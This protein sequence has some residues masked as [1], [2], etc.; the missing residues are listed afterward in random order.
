MNENGKLFI[1]DSSPPFFVRHPEDLINWSKIPYQQLEKDGDFHKKTHRKIRSD[2]EKY[3]HEIKKIGYNS[4]SLDDLSHMISFDFYPESLKKKIEKYKTGF[5][6]LFQKVKKY[7]LK[8][9]ITTDILFFNPWIEKET[10]NEHTKIIQFLFDAVEKLFKENEEIDGIIFRIGESDGI[11]VKGDFKSRLVLKT[12]EQVNYCLKK[13]LPLFEKYG[14][15]I[16]FRTWTTG[17]Y[18]IGDLMWNEKSFEKAFNGIESEFF[19]LSMKYG[20]TDF[21]R[22]LK[23]SPF[24][25][26][27][28]IK[29]IVEL[30][31]RREY[32]GFGE[33]PS[34]IGWD[35]KNYQNELKKN[36]SVIGI[37]AWCQTGGWSQFRNFTFLKNTSFWNE[38]NTFS[39]LKIFRYN[40]SAE[41]SIR[42]FYKEKDWKALLKFLRLS[43]EVIKDLLYDPEF[44]KKEL[45]FNRVRIPPLIH[46]I[47]DN[48]TITDA[49]IQFYNTY[50]VKKEESVRTAFRA[51]SKIKKMAKISS[52]SG[53]PYNFDF[54]HD[55]FKIIAY[56]RKLIYSKNKYKEFAYIHNLIEK[57]RIKYPTGYRFYISIKKEKNSIF[58]KLF[59]RLCVRKK[60]RYRLLD[61]ILFNSFTSK[62]FLVAYR[63][64]RRN[65]P[66]FINKR[67]M[68]VS[69]IFK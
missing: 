14:K 62:L 9:F 43:D 39:A 56:C 21:F 36:S 66:L 60:K 23:L 18:R 10:G 51:L 49:I 65:F 8:L 26:A 17:A 2:F 54:Q 4:I 48:V 32:E 29:K 22:Y 3:L 12:P 13:M 55:T 58:A 33:Y 59:I 6:R 53:F 42:E 47:W 37:Y 31:T 7:D 52:E 45:Y 69:T 11:D 1:I 19:I 68:P 16:I 27:G 30:Q 57:Y 44:A 24:L 46:I 64:L 50:V 61:R 28:G 15:Y 67:A 5:S 41:Q 40:Y 20:E 38:L 34:F 25:T 35:Y 63:V